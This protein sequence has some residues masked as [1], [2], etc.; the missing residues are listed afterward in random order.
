MHLSILFPLIYLFHFSSFCFQRY[1]DTFFPCTLCVICEPTVEAKCML[2]AVPIWKQTVWETTKGCVSVSKGSQSRSAL[3]ST[4]SLLLLLLRFTL[5]LLHQTLLSLPPRP[6]LL[7]PLHA[8]LTKAQPALFAECLFINFHSPLSEKLITAALLLVCISISVSLSQLSLSPC[9]QAL[10][11]TYFSSPP[12][13]FSLFLLF[14][15][16]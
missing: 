15:I 10:K 5:L 9:T 7:C 13:P 14:P 4:P 12:P 8:N 16:F 2:K 3:P 1:S 6:A 11:L